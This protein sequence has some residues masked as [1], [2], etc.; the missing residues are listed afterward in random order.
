MARTLSLY[1]TGTTGGGR[2]LAAFAIAPAIGSIIAVAAAV[3]FFM[4]QI[5]GEPPGGAAQ[6][7]AGGLFLTGWMV[8]AFGAPVAYIGM[9]LVGLPTW[10][11]L[12]LTRNES[13]LAYTLAGA[14]GGWCLAPELAGRKWA[15]FPMPAMGAFAGALTLWLFWRMAKRQP[16]WP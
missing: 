13:A 4:M 5:P 8:L 11:L 16:T 10:L 1:S 14:V 2:V 3:T 6:A 9:A 15:G 7:V 12:H